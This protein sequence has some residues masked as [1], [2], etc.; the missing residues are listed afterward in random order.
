MH[1]RLLKYNST[2]NIT[3]NTAWVCGSQTLCLSHTSENW[4]YSLHHWVQLLMAEGLLLLH[5]QAP[6]LEVQCKKAHAGILQR[7]RGLC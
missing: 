1:L 4:Q 2:L 7:Q 6:V 3:F 5:P